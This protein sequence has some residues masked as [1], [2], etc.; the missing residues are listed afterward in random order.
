MRSN[1]V[2]S[3]PYGGGVYFVLSKGWTGGLALKIGWSTNFRN[4]LNVL[5]QSHPFELELLIT[6]P[7]GTRRQERM[8]HGRFHAQRI[9]TPIG[10]EWFWF[11]GPLRKYVEKLRADERLTGPRK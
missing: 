10:V 3:A 6:I 4:R 11:E 1:R 9:A 7:G 8:L 5:Q 2:A